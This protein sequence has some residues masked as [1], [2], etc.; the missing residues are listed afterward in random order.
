MHSLMFAMMITTLFEER[1]WI[2]VFS[3][4]VTVFA[5]VYF[6][7]CQQIVMRFRRATETRA[8]NSKGGTRH[9]VQ[10]RD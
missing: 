1:L 4:L 2:A 10:H 5:A 7:R 3:G 8:P 9:H 6:M